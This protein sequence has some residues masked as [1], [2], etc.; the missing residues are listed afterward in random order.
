[1]TDKQRRSFA[2]RLDH[3]FTEVHPPSR[4]S[5]TYAEV[6][7]AIQEASGDAGKGVSASAI[8]QLRTGARS[9]PKMDTIQAL[10]D[11]FGVSPSY[12]FDDEEAERT[13]AEIKLAAAMRDGKVRQVA[14]RAN[15]LS[16]ESLHM[17]STV[18][19]QARRLEGLP[20]DDAAHSAE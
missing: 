16:T 3:L 5:F 2:Q 11:F 18:I 19:E 14:L 4:G 12:F 10:A 8:Q 15:G 1:M 20:G 17:L 7:A 9:N 13:E 6:A